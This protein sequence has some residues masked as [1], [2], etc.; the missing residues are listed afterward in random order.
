ML[1]NKTFYLSLLIVMGVVATISFF[2]DKQQAA[3]S[4]EVSNTNRQNEIRE[5]QEKIKDWEAVEASKMQSTNLSESISQL[6]NTG[7]SN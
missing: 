5:W 7:P 6:P 2:I 1:K 3:R 4:A